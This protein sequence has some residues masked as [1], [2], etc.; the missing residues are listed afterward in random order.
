M[1]HI[2]AW[3]QSHLVP[4]VKKISDNFWFSIV[5]DAVLY[6]VPFSM[7]SAIPSLWGII[8]KFVPTLPDLTP[9]STYSFGLIGLFVVF[10]IPFNAL[11]KLGRKDRATIAGFTGIGTFLLCMHMKLAP[12]TGLAQINMN[13]LGAPG[14]FTGIVV[15]LVVSL[16]YKLM[17]KFSFFGEDSPL[18]DFVK[19]WFDNII[20]IIISLFIGWILVDICNLNVFTLVTMLMKP[21]TGFAQTIWGVMFITLLQNIFYFFGV[22]GWVFTPVTRTITQAAIAENTAAIAAGK[23]ATNIYAYGFSRYTMIGGQACTL[24]L[25]FMMLF[26]KSRK[27]K[28]LGKATIIPSLFNINEPL[29]YGTVV[30][31][32]FMFI[33]IILISIIT[34]GLSWI[35]MHFGF[36]SINHVMFDMNFAPNAV[37]AFVMSGGDWRNVVLVCVNF[38]IA[39][40][41]WYPFFKASDKFELGKEQAR[42]AKEGK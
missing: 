1:K 16:V 8:R 31:N 14:M 25:A 12:A 19:N 37:S 3:I 15:G 21:V 33:P 4:I 28:L 7:V 39:A 27:N 18:P 35:V 20:A 11:E 42:L 2:E 32:P 29:F 9:L 13:Y 23:Q 6:I 41:I 36:A 17:A 38:M 10:V 34:S 30:N 5:A 22:S 24:P 40:L 26:A